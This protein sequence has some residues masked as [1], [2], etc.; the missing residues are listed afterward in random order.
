MLLFLLLLL[1]LLLMLREINENILYS[2]GEK[3][4]LTFENR[5]WNEMKGEKEKEEEKEKK[6][7]TKKKGSLR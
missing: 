2:E 7:Y 5:T 3:N 1:L 4:K 6:Q